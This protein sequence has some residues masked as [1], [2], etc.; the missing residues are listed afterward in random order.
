MAISQALPSAVDCCIRT[1][2]LP[3][4]LLRA[5]ARL[6]REYRFGV[7]YTSSLIKKGSADP[8]LLLLLRL[9]SESKLDL[10]RKSSEGIFFLLAAARLYTLPYFSFTPV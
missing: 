5:C 8:S 9:S 10:R 3:Q 1:G 7:Y 4:T 2:A 6:E